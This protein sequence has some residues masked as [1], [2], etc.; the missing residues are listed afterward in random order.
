MDEWNDEII[1]SLGLFYNMFFDLITKIDWIIYFNYEI[2]KA[3]HFLIN[4]RS[5]SKSRKLI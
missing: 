4:T 1:N 3:R 2:A 5:Q